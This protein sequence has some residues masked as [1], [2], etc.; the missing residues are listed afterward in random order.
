MKLNNKNFS[1]LF[2]LFVLAQVL[3]ACKQ[4]DEMFRQYVQENGIVYPAKANKAIAMTGLMSVN[5]KWENTTRTVTSARI[6]WNNYEDSVIV[7]ITPEIDTVRQNIELPEGIY[8][9]IIRTFDKD[10]NISVPVEVVGKSIGERFISDFF[11]RQILNYGS[12]GGANLT[13]NWDEA[14]VVKGAV[15]CELFYKDINNI[16][17]TIRI[18]VTETITV[19][20]DYKPDTP[21]KYCTFYKPEPKNP[22]LI[23]STPYEEFEV[24][25]SS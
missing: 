20:E 19:I 7:N 16:E 13:I 15:Y 4:Q 21:F 18:P 25:L 23:F 11:N 8:T 10:E 1:Y 2:S 6:W 14:D 3:F 17:K 12:Y 22:L 5:I 9:F 24:Q